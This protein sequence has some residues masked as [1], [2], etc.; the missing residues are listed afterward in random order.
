MPQRQRRQRAF[1][2]HEPHNNRVIAITDEHPNNY[3]LCRFP[4]CTRIAQFDTRFKG[5]HLGRLDFAFKQRGLTSAWLLSL[6][7]STS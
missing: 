4:G 6:H 2:Y 1:S 5:H 7:E 3:V